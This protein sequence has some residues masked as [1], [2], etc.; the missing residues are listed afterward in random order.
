MLWYTSESQYFCGCHTYR[1]ENNFSRR[2]KGSPQMRIGIL[3]WFS[4]N[5]CCKAGSAHAFAFVLICIPMSRLHQHLLSQ[6]HALHRQAESQKRKDCPMVRPLFWTMGDLPQIYIL[7]K[8]LFKNK[9]CRIRWSVPAWL[10]PTF[11]LASLNK[12]RYFCTTLPSV[13]TRP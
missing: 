6:L 2:F 7:K 5:P 1:W 12:L 13:S 11:E 4:H 9:R 10:L 8:G 3:H